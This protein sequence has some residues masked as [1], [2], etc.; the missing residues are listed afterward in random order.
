[1]KKIKIIIAL[2]AVSLLAVNCRK[3][4]DVNK[5]PNN[6]LSVSEGLI[7][8]PAEITLST[9]VVGGYNGVTLSYW[10]QYLSLNQSSPDVETYYI[11][12]ADVDNSWTFY[13]YP[14][15]LNNL[16]N[17]VIQAEAAGHV[18]YAAIGKTL[19]AYSLAIITDEWGDVPYSQALKFPAVLKP[20]YDT[21]ESIYGSIQS[22]LDS[23]IYYAGQPTSLQPAGGDD[24]IYGGDMSKW[25]KFAYM[26]KARYYLRLS[27]APGHTA[28]VQADSALTALQNGFASNDDNA[29]AP[30]PGTPG[31]E[32]PWY[33]NTLP[34]AGG[35]VMSSSFVD[36]LVARKDPRLPIIATK[37]KHGNYAGRIIGSDP[38]ADPDSFSVVNTFYGGYLPL[39]PNNSAG[40]AAS[41]FLATYA[42]QLFIA[43]EATFYKSGTAAA[44]PIYGAAIGAHMDMLGVAA[45]DKATYIASRG[46]L[47]DEN[48]VH[49]IIDE[50]Y[51]AD[52][53]SLETYND[54]RRTGFPVLQLAQNP[55]V[56]YI[57]QR[58]PYPTNAI[59]KVFRQ[60]LLVLSKF[61]NFRFQLHLTRQSFIFPAQSSLLIA[62]M[63]YPG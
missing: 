51:V 3:F 40:A 35:V 48:A 17:M 62:F 19:M 47:T 22:L 6:P 61:M 16:N 28:S 56:N 9:N 7:L 33:E 53:L 23:A 25:T 12:P 55:Y 13:L 37:G 32:N 26:L 45:A 49:Q 38:A 39:S 11:L 31:S 4:L 14:N 41:V 63:R 36:S 46:P 5:D 8:S 34:G 44:T 57:P 18:E 24:Y 60:P 54:W 43:S 15:I 10:M 42:E 58:W 27:A 50:K 30:Y 59:L 29:L 20:K 21:Q 1:M 2:A 52:F